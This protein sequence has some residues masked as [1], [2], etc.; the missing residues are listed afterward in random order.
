LVGGPCVNSLVAA[1]ADAGK[2]DYT[3]TLWPG[4]NFGMVKLVEGG[5]ATAKNV[6]VVA[7]TRADD[8]RM[9][10]SLLQR[11]TEFADELSGNTAVKVTSLSAAGI[12]P[13]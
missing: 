5:F 9:A 8:T 2:F 10:T 11:Y 1:L 4:E 3:C 12:T 7:G 6:V 13:V